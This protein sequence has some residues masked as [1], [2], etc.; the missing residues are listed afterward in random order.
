MTTAVRTEYDSLRFD[1]KWLPTATG[2][3]VE[4]SLEYKSIDGA[5]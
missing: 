2:Q 3:R 1:G 4:G 5:P